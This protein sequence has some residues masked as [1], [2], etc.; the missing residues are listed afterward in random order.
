MSERCFSGRYTSCCCIRKGFL[1]P[2]I[3]DSNDS[4]DEDIVRSS[5]GK[6]QNMFHV[7]AVPGAVESVSLLLP[8]AVT[9]C[10]ARR[11]T[12]RL[13]NTC[14]KCG[15]ISFPCRLEA[16]LHFALE[17]VVL[18]F[19][20]QILGLVEGF[21]ELVEP[22]LQLVP[23]GALLSRSSCGRMVVSSSWSSRA[24]STPR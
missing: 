16:A 10:L 8:A 12:K 6:K 1:D 20:N 9:S 18:V 17:E 5:R 22:C 24:M 3:F 13:Q 7:V 14:F 11:S 21:F 15:G 19:I 23:V 4:A 2:H